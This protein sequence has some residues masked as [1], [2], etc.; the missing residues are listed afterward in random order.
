MPRYAARRLPSI[1]TKSRS[2]SRT[3]STLCSRSGVRPDQ[4]TVGPQLHTNAS[5]ANPT[6]RNRMSSKP[7]SGTRTAG[8]DRT[9]A[10]DHLDVD[11]YAEVA[12]HERAQCLA[13]TDREETP[14]CEAPER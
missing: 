13:R 1:T 8:L 3:T 2:L 11:F 5:A 14:R 4:I 9:H 12:M 10:V 7:R 6:R